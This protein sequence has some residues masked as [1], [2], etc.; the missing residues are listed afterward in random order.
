MNGLLHG[1]GMRDIDCLAH[2]AVAR[3]RAREM[4]YRDRYDAAWHAIAELLCSSEHVPQAAELKNA[5]AAAVNRLAQDEG[6]HH[7]RDRRNWGAGLESMAAFQRFW[8]LARCPGRAPEEGV[9][10]RLALAQIWAAISPWHR[11]V[12][13]AMAV[14]EDHQAAAAAVGRSYACFTSHLKNARREFY[15]LWHEGEKPPRVWGRA[16]RRHGRRS[17][18]QLLVNRRQ[19]QARRMAAAGDPS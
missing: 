12:I 8:S 2:A 19:Q 1:L 5:G 3:A 9:T 11:E 14:H 13:T 16:D 18:T 15:A 4:D 17:A 7:G 6:R 10:E